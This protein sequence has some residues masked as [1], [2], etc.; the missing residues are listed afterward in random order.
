MLGT[1]ILNVST[2]LYGLNEIV[3][4]F[5]VTSIQEM[6]GPS[7]LLHIGSVEEVV[8]RLLDSALEA[9][10]EETAACQAV[11]QAFEK[12]VASGSGPA[13]VARFDELIALDRATQQREAVAVTG[14]HPKTAL[15]LERIL[16]AIQDLECRSGIAALIAVAVAARGS[17]SDNP[18]GDKLLARLIYCMER[19]LFKQRILRLF[20]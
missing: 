16:D 9:T 19:Y 7:S 12:V 20:V 8:L 5:L 3:G 10:R 1:K 17:L 15:V 4:E 11:R 6:L 2:N 14:A 13:F 18:L